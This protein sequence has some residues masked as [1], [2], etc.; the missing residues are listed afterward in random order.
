MRQ[1]ML[2]RGGEGGFVD[3]AHGYVGGVGETPAIV[4]FGF[5]ADDLSGEA[6]ELD[7]DG[8]VG[9]GDFG[10]VALGDVAMD[11]M[12]THAEGGCLAQE[13]IGEVMKVSP[14]TVRSEWRLARL[15][16]LRELSRSATSEE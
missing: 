12:D 5:D 13:E 1:K 11:G 10:E 16:L 7:G 8:A 2:V 6:F 4:V 15:W 14:R 9:G 3:E